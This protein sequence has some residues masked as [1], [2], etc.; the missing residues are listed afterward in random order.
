M[1]AMGRRNFIGQVPADRSN[2]CLP[3]GR[4]QPRR[5]G[6]RRKCQCHGLTAPDGAYKTAKR[7]AGVDD[8]S[9]FFMKVSP[10]GQMIGR[11]GEI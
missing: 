9:T 10:S 7:R 1:G 8:S 3:K 4:L 2:D 6:G 5:G 11:T